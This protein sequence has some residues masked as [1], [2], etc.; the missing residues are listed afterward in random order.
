M[1]LETRACVLLFL[2]QRLELIT[3]DT[4]EQIGVSQLNVVNWDGAWLLYS[5]TVHIQVMN[6][7]D[8]KGQGRLQGGYVALC[9]LVIFK[10]QEL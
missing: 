1:N 6:V 9:C 8:C 3:A 7:I 5:L 10:G 4:R 2:V